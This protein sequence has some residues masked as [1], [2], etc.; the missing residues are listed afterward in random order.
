MVNLQA[1]ETGA[2][3]SRRFQKRDAENIASRNAGILLQVRPALSRAPFPQ[4][5]HGMTSELPLNLLGKHG[6]KQPTS[7]PQL[8]QASANQIWCKMGGDIYPQNFALAAKPDWP[9]L[10]HQIPPRLRET[11]LRNGAI[12]RPRTRMNKTECC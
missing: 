1:C 7:S 11:S 3:P 5:E 9:H 10:T 8:R 6:T 2:G 4:R 12:A